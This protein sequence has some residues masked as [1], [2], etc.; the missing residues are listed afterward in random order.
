MNHPYDRSVL[1]CSSPGRSPVILP[2]RLRPKMK[3]ERGPMK[4][5]K[6]AA[7][8]RRLLPLIS[9]SGRRQMST[10]A[11]ISS[12]ICTTPD[13]TTP[14]RCLALSSLHLLLAIATLP[15]IITRSSGK[16]NVQ[17]VGYSCLISMNHIYSQ[18]RPNAACVGLFRVSIIFCRMASSLARWRRDES[19][20]SDFRVA[21]RWP[22][23]GGNPA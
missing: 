12:V 16:I 8:Q 3:Y 6:A 10:R 21:L 1:P 15:S 14:R 4:L 20:I 22:L 13:S 7:V 2:H 18:S 19:K 5:T 9:S 17:R 11:A 23:A